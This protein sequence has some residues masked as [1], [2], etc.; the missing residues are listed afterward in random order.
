MAFVGAFRAEAAKFSFFFYIME[1]LPRKNPIS[2]VAPQIIFKKRKLPLI[3][4][5]EFLVT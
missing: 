5:R 3:R 1:N 4:K 2:Q